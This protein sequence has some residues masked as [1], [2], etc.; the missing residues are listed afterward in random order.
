MARSGDEV[1]FGLEE[2]CVPEREIWP[3]VD[4]ALAQVG[5]PYPRD[6]PT[7]ALSGGEKQRLALAAV[8]ALRPRILLLDEPT[9]SLDPA[10]ARDLY[11]ALSRLDRSTTVVLVEHHLDLAL[12]LVDRIVAV[13]GER[14]VTVDGT[15]RTVLERDRG[16]LEAL[17]TWLPDAPAPAPIA[18]G[19]GG[20]DVVIARDVGF[21]YPRAARDA[22]AGADLRLGTGEC[23]AITGPNGSGKSTLLLIL[24]GLVRPQRG[25]V[26]AETLDP[27]TP[28]PWRWRAPTLA[29]R[30]GSVFQD[31]DHQFLTASVLEE[32]GLGSRLQGA[33]EAE[34]R[35]RAAL[36]V[37]RL[38]L[39]HVAAASP[40]TLSGGEKRRLSVGTALATVPRALFLDEPSYGQDRATF[41]GLIGLLRE[42]HVQGAAL[43]AA[44][45]EAA[46]VT[47]M[48]GR[49]VALE[50]SA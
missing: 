50:R 30:F 47:A 41:V 8:L 46:L 4:E 19:A 23:L 39:G 32:L 36:L 42:A 44:T 28:E 31:P 25:S 10:G 45:H 14:G 48:G 37:E 17:G 22:L 6:H 5:F 35:R 34:A 13:D 1:A 12:P 43:C 29:S 26:R 38:G 16:E 11:E 9:S 20:P 49:T 2:R 40:F 24:G 15:A 21:R 7:A 3:R 18:G 27:R 33:S